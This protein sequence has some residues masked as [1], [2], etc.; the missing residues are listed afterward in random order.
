MADADQIKRLF[1]EVFRQK[2]AFASLYP[3]RPTPFWRRVRAW[4]RGVSWEW[5]EREYIPLKDQLPP[6][7]NWS[8]GGILRD[9]DK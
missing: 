1:E 2:A 5:T 8:S 9:L 3:S 7:P 6:N 4:L